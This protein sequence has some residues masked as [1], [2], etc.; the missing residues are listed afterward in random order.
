MANRKRTNAT[1]ETVVGVFLDQQHAN[2]ATQYL[3]Q[4]G[5]D[6]QIADKSA[7]KAFRSTGLEDDVVNL[8]ESRL[9]Q[10]NTIVTVTGNNGEEAMRQML[11]MGAEYIN[12]SDKGGTPRYNWM[13]GQ[14]QQ[15]NYYQNLDRSRRQYGMW[16][17]TRGRALNEDEVRVQL[18]EET[19]QPVKQAVQTGEVGVHK[20]VREQQHE[21]PVNLR[22]EEVT[23]DRQA[24]DRPADPREIGDMRE[25]SFSVP[26]YEERAELQKQAR[27]YEEVTLSKQPIEEQRT[28]T[29]TTRREELDVTENGDAALRGNPAV[30][31]G[32][33]WTE[34]MPTYRSR[35]EQSHRGG[36]WQEAEPAY[37]YAYEMSNN[38]RY[39]G[40][41]Y[42]EIENDLRN[43]WQNR[44]EPTAWDK[45]STNVREAWN[46]VTS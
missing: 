26:V 31:T 20:T 13:E 29:G 16:D 28:V 30:R 17:Q 19:L 24:V 11:Q 15:A 43:D 38:P 3:Q 9:S 34:V 1:N 27:V 25:E 5:Y 41:S 21:V 10:G 32:E 8:Y 12:I 36:S 14:A 40:R 4:Q 23:I 35:W 42:T 39:R 45:V 33:N 46:D 22:R 44:G 37:R 7:I 2:Q 18:R 6:A